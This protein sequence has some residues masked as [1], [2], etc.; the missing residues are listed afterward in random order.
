[1]IDRHGN[2]TDDSDR[3]IS[4][5]ETFDSDPVGDRD[6]MH[7]DAPGDGP[8]CGGRRYEHGHNYGCQGCR[9]CSPPD[10]EYRPYGWQIEKFE[11]PGLERANLAA[12]AELDKR[13]AGKYTSAWVSDWG[14]SR[15]RYAPPTLSPS[16]R[17]FRDL[18]WAAWTQH[19]AQLAAAAEAFW[20]LL[21]DECETHKEA[22]DR[23]S[24][25]AD[26]HSGR[27]RKGR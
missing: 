21:C 17:A 11:D 5:C 8:S 25:W 1:M 2:P 26:L 10:S 14:M 18:C 6:I 3:M 19:D 9:K 23:Y 15:G 27:I 12:W 4:W 16:D 22:A 20:A 24:D 7:D 13:P